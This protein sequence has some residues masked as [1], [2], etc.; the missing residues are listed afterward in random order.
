MEARFPVATYARTLS[1]EDRALF[2]GL[3]MFRFDPL[4]AIKVFERYRV[5]LR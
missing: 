3:R 5:R 1:N 2:M 4:L